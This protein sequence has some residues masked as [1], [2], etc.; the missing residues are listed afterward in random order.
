MSMN[1]K[2][3]RGYGECQLIRSVAV[4][5]SSNTGSA[6]VLLE[7][8]RAAAGVMGYMPDDTGGL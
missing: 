8:Q 1:F 5:C 4:C 7:H 6:E 2:F 3:S